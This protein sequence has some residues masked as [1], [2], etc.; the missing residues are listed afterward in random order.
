MTDRKTKVGAS[1]PAPAAVADP[2]TP[3]ANE[4]TEPLTSAHL[5]EALTAHLR[6]PKLLRVP[7]AT[8]LPTDDTLH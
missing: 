6:R 7:R 4:A 8:P 1:T 3:E 2:T 5:A